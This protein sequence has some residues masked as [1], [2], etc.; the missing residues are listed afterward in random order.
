MC[1]EKDIDCS[2]VV[3][4]YNREA[5]LDRCLE[6]LVYQRTTR[7]FEIILVDDGSPDK[8]GEICDSYAANDSRIQV[9]HKVNG[10]QSSARNAGIKAA[11]GEYIGFMDHDDIV[12][13]KWCEVL[14]QNAKEHNADIGISLDGDADRAGFVDERGEFVRPD[15]ITGILAEYYLEK[16][17][18]KPVLC[19]IHTSRGVTEYVKKL[20]GV[21]HLWK[22]GH[23]FAKVKLRELGAIVGG[24]LAG[25][26][27]FRDF[28]CCHCRE[29]REVKTCSVSILVRTSLF[30]VRTKYFTECFLKQV[31]CRVITACFCT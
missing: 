16:E 21:P 31:C 7:T 1:L 10:G 27:Y 29:M 2:F 17:P 19:D 6:S 22:V 11:R 20:G 15:I 9:I 12:E 25:H 28:F 3:A 26:Y 8:T 4:I 23:A 18:G 24:E 14:Y 5:T 30:Y 13:P